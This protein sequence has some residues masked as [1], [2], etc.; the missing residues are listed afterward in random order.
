MLEIPI[1]GAVSCFYTK[2]KATVDLESV[3]DD[4]CAYIV[5]CLCPSHE[6]YTMTL[7]RANISDCAQ[8]LFQLPPGFVGSIFEAS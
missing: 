6:Q 3:L 8:C 4:H 5:I 1:R 7:R 2:W